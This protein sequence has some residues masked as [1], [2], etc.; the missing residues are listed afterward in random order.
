M[1]DGAGGQALW[2]LHNTIGR[3]THGELSG[4]VDVARPIFRLRGNSFHDKEVTCAL[5]GV[6]RNDESVAGVDAETATGSQWWP[7]PVAE[8][9]VRG[10]DLVASYRPVNDWPYSPQLYWQANTLD[11][12]E[13]VLASLS[14]TVCLQTHL[15]DTCPQIS[16][17]SQ[18]PS[19]EL[20]RLSIREDG[21]AS[22]EPVVERDC[23][24]PEGSLLCT[25]RRLK[26]APMSYVEVMPATDFRELKLQ[27]DGGGNGNSRSEWLLFA[28]FLEKGV[29]RK[30]RVQAALVPQQNDVELALECCR[31]L[32]QCPLPLTT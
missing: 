5:L 30:A 2:S 27:A 22:V 1:D 14:L 13:G 8:V 9:Y 7:L 10:N 11:A 16:V 21:L 26:G 20:L 24:A 15:L 23:V 12:V 25:I 19:R 18:M 4:D 17:A 3:L 6:A 29:I 32:E 28:D 31:A